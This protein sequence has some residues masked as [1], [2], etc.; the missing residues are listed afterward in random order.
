[1]FRILLRERDRNPGSVEGW[2][3]SHPVEESRVRT[4]EEE[5]AKLDPVVLSSL[6]R[7]TPA[8]QAFKRRL[9]GLP[10]TV[11]QR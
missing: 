6:T 1:M 8:F 5:I 11:R 3:A 10:R 4:T 7:D 2:F 9:A